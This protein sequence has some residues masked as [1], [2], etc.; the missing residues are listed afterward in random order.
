MDPGTG[1]AIL[2]LSIAGKEGVA[3]VAEF[4]RQIVTP[5]AKAIG[6]GLATPVKRWAES[7]DRRAEKI[8]MDA[9]VMLDEAGITPQAVPDQVS[10][11]L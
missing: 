8:V 9:A 5:T 2:G 1:A 3:V 11:P 10:I 6:E 7:R 4:V